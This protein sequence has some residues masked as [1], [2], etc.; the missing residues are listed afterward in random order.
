MTTMKEELERHTYKW[1]SRSQILVQ[2][3]PPTIVLVVSSLSAFTE[4]WRPSE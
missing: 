4:E 2:T 3:K 1:I